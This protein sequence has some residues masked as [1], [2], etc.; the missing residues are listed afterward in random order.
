[1]VQLIKEYFFSSIQQ[2]IFPNKIA[3]SYKLSSVKY[4]GYR[5]KQKDLKA[6][7]R[8]RAFHN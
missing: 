2:A 5:G 1:M 4:I 6:T 7:F 3:N 8:R